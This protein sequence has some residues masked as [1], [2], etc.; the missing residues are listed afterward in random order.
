MITQLKIYLSG[1]NFNFW[2]LLFPVS[3]SSSSCHWV[4]E[5]RQGV[6]GGLRRNVGSL[7]SCR[8]RVWWSSLAHD[9]ASVCVRVTVHEEGRQGVRLI[10][11]RK[12]ENKMDRRR[13]RTVIFGPVWQ[14][15]R[16]RKRVHWESG[17]RDGEKD[18]EQ[19]RAPWKRTCK[20]VYEESRGGG[21]RVAAPSCSC[22]F[23]RPHGRTRSPTLAFFFSL[24]LFSV[25]VSLSISLGLSF[26]AGSYA[27][28]LARTPLVSW[29]APHSLT[30]NCGART[31]AR[32]RATERHSPF[33]SHH[34]SSWN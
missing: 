4:Q 28:V 7:P 25:P 2:I 21:G 5:V 30:R 24:S 10:G 1:N 11:A 20:M 27:R 33:A 22:R 29:R 8:W 9:S 18:R 34:S 31:F 19:E 32:I 3:L 16:E 6:D 14:R 17:G 26:P 12:K 15:E 13:K 23:R